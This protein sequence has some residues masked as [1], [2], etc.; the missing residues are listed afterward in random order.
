MRRL[1]ILIVIFGLAVPIALGQGATPERRAKQNCNLATIVADLP[2]FAPS[3]TETATGEDVRTVFQNLMK[4][5]RNHLRSF[6]ALL[7]SN[8]VEYTAVAID[9]VLFDQIVLSARERGL[10]DAEGT[11]ST[12]PACTQYRNAGWNGRERRRHR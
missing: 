10:L 12:N 6:F 4:G 7:E 11:L 1:C 2:Y 9:Q 3:A 8:G 5:S